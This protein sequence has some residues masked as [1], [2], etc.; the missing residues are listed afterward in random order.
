MHVQGLGCIHIIYTAWKCWLLNINIF[1]YFLY[2]GFI[3]NFLF[4]RCKADYFGVGLMFIS[5][6]R[7]EFSKQT[8]RIVKSELNRNVQGRHKTSARF[9]KFAKMNL[10]VI[11]MNDSRQ[12]MKLSLI[13]FNMKWQRVRQCVLDLRCHVGPAR[14]DPVKLSPRRLYR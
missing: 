1:T 4:W 6:W 12:W 14:L 11:E 13:N 7:G 3:S 9:V 8:C 2:L 10:W 5:I